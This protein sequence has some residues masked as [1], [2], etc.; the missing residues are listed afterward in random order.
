MAPLAWLVFAAAAVDPSLVPPSSQASPEG[1]GQVI[2]LVVAEVGD[3]VITLSELIAE[4]GWVLVRTRGPEVALEGGLPRSLLRSVLESMVNRQLLLQELRRLQLEDVE[5]RAVD[6][7]FDRFARRFAS[8][9][10]AAAF[11]ASFGFEQPAPGQPPP[12]LARRIRSDLR[13]DRFL[14]VRLETEVDLKAVQRCLQV[15]RA[16]FEGLPPEEARRR[17]AERLE[18]QLRERALH[19]LLAD[20]RAQTDI[21]YTPGYGPS[22]EPSDEAEFSCPLPDA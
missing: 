16:R 10:Q 19:R 3:E 4:T 20:L 14:A 12:L 8:E 2:D 9:R 7:E 5:Q 22:P 18:S 11:Y 15:E 6:A 21:V 1:E 13:A 17:V